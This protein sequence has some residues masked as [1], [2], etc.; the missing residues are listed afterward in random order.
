LLASAKAFSAFFALASADL[1]DFSA[2]TLAAVAASKAFRETLSSASSKEMRALAIAKASARQQ[3]GKRKL[4][5]KQRRA[6]KI[7]K[8]KEKEFTFESSSSFQVLSTLSAQGSKLFQQ[9]LN[10]EEHVSIWMT[11]GK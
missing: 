4:S 6:C 2:L 7:K 8:M 10:K 11:Q 5:N 1:F 9:Y 3:G